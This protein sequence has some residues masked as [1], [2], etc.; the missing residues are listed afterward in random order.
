MLPHKS[1]LTFITQLPLLPTA[2]VI[3]VFKV[4]RLHLHRTVFPFVHTVPF[5]GVQT[6]L[7]PALGR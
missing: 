5:N 2:G 1:I 3:S 6:H 4:P 7:L